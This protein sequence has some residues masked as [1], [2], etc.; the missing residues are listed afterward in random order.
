MTTVG[1][2]DLAA[3]GATGWLLGTFLFWSGWSKSLWA[4]PEHVFL[5]LLGIVSLRLI[6]API[7][8]PRLSPRRVVAVGVA[9]YALLF[10]FVTVTHHLTFRTHALDLGYYVQL[11]WNLSRGQGPYVSLPEM[12]AWGDHLSPIMYLFAPAFLILP[13]APVLLVAQS[14][15]LAA[16]ALPVFGIARYYLG[17]ERPAAAFALLYLVNPSLHG[18]NVRDFHAA[19][20]AIPLILTAMYCALICRPWLFAAA[21]GMTLMTREDATIPVAG[22]GAW[23]A[24]CRGQWLAGAGLAVGALGLLFSEVRWIIPHYRGQAYPHLARYVYL[25]G[26]LGEILL[27][28]VRHPL[29]VLGVVFS[30]GRIVYLLAMLGPLAF[31]PLL[32]PGALLG[33]APPLFQNLL[34]SDPVLHSYRTQYQSF[35]LPFFILGAIVGYK[36]V[37]VAGA[38]RW[39]AA[40]MTVAFAL[41]LALAASA[42]NDLAVARWWPTGEQREAYGVM[43]RIPAAASV[44]AQDRYVPHVSL[45]RLVTVFPVGLDRADYVLLNMQTYPWRDQPNVTLERVGDAVTIVTADGSRLRYTVDAESGPYLLLRR[46]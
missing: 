44:S 43:A 2:I 46:L 29:R 42:A 35:V 19:A 14:V 36:R 25:G 37:M 16:G 34:G 22:L 40:I 33:V 41:S 18:I 38:G 27:T 26:S 24:V 6:V 39:G 17:D 11:T 5:L 21:V 3:L 7:A 20:L 1:V 23:L 32:A 4:R 9:A 8:V 10:S 12:N 45:R 30:S 31:L 13:G 28:L 15:A